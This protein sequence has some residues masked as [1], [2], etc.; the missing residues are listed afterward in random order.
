MSQV[1]QEC[2]QYFKDTLSIYMIN[3]FKNV[4]GENWLEST[5][6]PP[7]KDSL[8]TIKK[9]PKE[10]D[11]NILVNLIHLHWDLV[12]S[13]LI[14]DALPK[15]IFTVIRIHRNAWAH[16][17]KM[18]EREIYRI[19]DELEWVLKS[20]GLNSQLIEQ[21]RIEILNNLSTL[22]NIYQN[23]R[24]KFLCAGCQIYFF[25]DTKFEC[26]TCGI[27]SCTKCM[28]EWFNNKGGICPQCARSIS[29]EEISEISTRYELLYNIS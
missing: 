7:G 27:L 19:I 17:K 5:L 8:M 12:F 6:N 20:L 9:N 1:V 23:S 2:M 10:W 13:R 18:S 22:S 15:A 16:Q 11:L 26:F 25:V 28:I 29:H 21:K 24:P 4:Y 3:Q 14:S